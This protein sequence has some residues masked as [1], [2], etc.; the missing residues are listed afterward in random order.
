MRLKIYRA[1]NVADA[2]AQLRRELGPEALILSTKRVAG[3]VELTA[4]IDTAD[5]Q[6]PAPAAPEAFDAAYHGVPATLAA[7]LSGG[8]LADKLRTSLRFAA[9]PAGILIVVGHPGAGKTLSVARLATR[10]VLAGARPL[11]ITADSRRAGGAEELAAYTRLLGLTLLV[12]GSPAMLTRA[13][14]QAEPGSAVLIDTAGIDP[15]NT[16]DT[17]ALAALMAVAGAGRMTACAQPGGAVLVM[18]AGAHP[19]EA[20]EQAEAFRRL[21]VSHLLPTRLDM[22]RRLGSVL[23]A[24]A[25][26]LAL[27][28]AGVGTG[29]TDGLVP[30]TPEF[31]AAR[32]TNAASPPRAAPPATVSPALRTPVFPAARTRVGQIWDDSPHG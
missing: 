10:S 12:A 25:T 13:L 15:F 6:I 27:T 32:L 29:A 16:A 28:E 3:G 9:L 18:Q 23:T 19:D 30:I 21:S 20:A 4:A 17:D 8:A 5:E 22:T 14:G 2:M 11:V 31:L 24:A 1:P 7:K 26:G